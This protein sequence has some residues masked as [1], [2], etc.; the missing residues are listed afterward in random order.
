[1]QFINIETWCQK[2]FGVIKN[3][4]KRGVGVGFLIQNGGSRIERIVKTAIK[5][6]RYYATTNANATRAI[7]KN[8]YK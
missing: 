3:K 1:V 6:Y 8:K 2:K 5:D 4:N 7:S